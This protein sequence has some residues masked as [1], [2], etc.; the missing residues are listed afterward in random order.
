MSI[1]STMY[2]IIIIILLVVLHSLVSKTT[3]YVYTLSY[4][5]LYDNCII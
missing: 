1:A 4:A 3:I 5:Q 2:N